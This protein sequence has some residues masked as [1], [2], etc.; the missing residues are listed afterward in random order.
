M[1]R[2]R[3]SGDEEL[4]IVAQSDLVL[5]GDGIEGDAIELTWGQTARVGVAAR[6]LSLLR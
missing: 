2:G 3:L 6:T 1:H 4:G 5:F